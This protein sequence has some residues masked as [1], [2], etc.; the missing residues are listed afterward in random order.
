MP[1]G[2]VTAEM[3]RGPKGQNRPA[4]HDTPPA[5]AMRLRLC[6]ECGTPED[7]IQAAF[8]RM[9]ATPFRAGQTL[10]MKV[11]EFNDEEPEPEPPPVGEHDLQVDH[12]VDHHP[13]PDRP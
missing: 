11:P 12:V 8:C 4:A 2:I 13:V 7:D 9:C 1:T 6:H 5:A 3:V 10:V